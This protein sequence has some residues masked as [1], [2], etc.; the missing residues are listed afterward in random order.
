MKKFLMISGIIAITSL[1]FGKEVI[2]APA[3]AVEPVEVAIEDD[4]VPVPG[5]FSMFK[6]KKFTE[7]EAVPSF[8]LG[9][10]VGMVP[11]WG[12]GFAGISGRHNSDTT[13]GAFALGMGFGDPFT[14]LGG[15]ATLALGSIDPRDGGAGNRGTLNLSTG[16]HFA[17]H[18]LGVAVGVSNIDL[19][20]ADSEDEFDPS[21]YGSVT[22]LLP[23]LPKPVVLTAGLGNNVY[24]DS[25]SDGNLESKIGGFAAVAVYLMPQ[26]SLIADYTSGITTAGIG[27]VPFPKLPVSFTMGASD[28]FRHAEENKVSFIAGISAAYKF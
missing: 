2:S 10:P 16:K 12:V 22:K 28:L 8:S 24:S 21:F 17:R 14:S 19:W 1:S 11:G 3:I 23:N 13:D 27:F 9:A 20:H 26:L 7:L 15:A 5:N 6:V 18:G 25:K 4:N